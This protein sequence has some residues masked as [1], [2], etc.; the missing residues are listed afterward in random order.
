MGSLDAFL[1]CSIGGTGFQLVDYSVRSD[2]VIEEGI[3]RVGTRVQIEGEGYIESVSQAAHS[4]A[5]AAA[6]AGLDVAGQDIIVKGFGGVVELQLLAAWCKDGGPHVSFQMLPQ[7]D[8]S[9][10]RRA[11][12]FTATGERSWT[13]GEDPDDPGESA[14]REVIATEEGGMRTATIT[15]Q[16]RG[17]DALQR[18]SDIWLPFWFISY[19]QAQWT[20][21]WQTDA[22]WAD[23]EL[24]YTITFSELGEPLPE[25]PDGP[26]IGEVQLQKGADF[27]E[28]GLVTRTWAWEVVYGGDSSQIW[29]ALR[30]KC[31]GII[32]RQT[33]SEQ[34]YHQRRLS[35]TFTTL[36]GPD[37]NIPDLLEW[38]HSVEIPTEGSGRLEATEY[39]G[40]GRALLAY[41]PAPAYAATQSGRAT[42]LGRFPNAPG[43]LWPAN[44][45]EVPVISRRWVNEYV[46]ET[47]WRYAFLADSNTPFEMNATAL[48][49]LK[50]PSG[51]DAVALAKQVFVG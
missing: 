40:A 38:E 8:L 39:P 3:G 48:E 12:R 7:K 41:T 15:G 13:A 23:D 19:P 35:V 45:A 18:F 32:I 9:P 4:A 29:S 33:A 20:S 6:I 24:K 37:A 42:G 1:D 10:L 21:K 49:K 31:E 2:P 5:I 27:D 36:S 11:F 26:W 30:R 28:R 50:R 34:V 16:V 44:L 46:A 17:P 14:Y 43:P 22:N 47:S 51:M 25:L